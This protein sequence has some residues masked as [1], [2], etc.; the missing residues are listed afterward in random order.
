MKLTETEREK[1][2]ARLSQD[3][4][5]A[6]PIDAIPLEK[7]RYYE[8]VAEAHRVTQEPAPV[9]IAGL[10]ESGERWLALKGAHGP[11]IGC[12]VKFGI[13][14]GWKPDRKKPPHSLKLGPCV[15][16]P[17]HGFLIEEADISG[18]E[19]VTRSEKP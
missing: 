8:S 14:R 11:V 10:S 16:G 19:D 15:I 4:R 1:C 18:A 17:A 5:N 3:A 12:S 7:R 13:P 2:R 9:A 6:V